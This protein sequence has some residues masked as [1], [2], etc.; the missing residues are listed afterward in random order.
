MAKELNLKLVR[1]VPVDIYTFMSNNKRT[2]KFKEYEII[3]KAISSS[4]TLFLK[5]LGISTICDKIKGQNID[6]A[7]EQT[8]FVKGLQLADT[9]KHSPESKTDILIGSDCYW[10]VVTGE[11]KRYSRAE[12]VAISTIF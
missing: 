4:K 9:G 6:L 2:I 7:V 10:K 1:E 11:V 5:V 12:M 8:E 3:V